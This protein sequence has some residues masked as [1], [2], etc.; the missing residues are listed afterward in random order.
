MGLLTALTM[1]RPLAIATKSALAMAPGVPASRRTSNGL[2][3]VG[4]VQVY[5]VFAANCT[6]TRSP[7]C[8]VRCCPALATFNSKVLDDAWA[9]T[10]T[11]RV[12]RI[13][14]IGQATP[15]AQMGRPVDVTVDVPTES[16][17]SV[18]VVGPTLDIEIVV[19]RSDGGLMRGTDQR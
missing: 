12:Q 10:I 13:K 15:F 2:D 19:T 17:R 6:C 11:S 14:Y 8:R 16:A 9:L 7:R 1:T 18:T 4:S 3:D 5:I